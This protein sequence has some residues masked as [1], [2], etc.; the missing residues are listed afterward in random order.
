VFFLAVAG[1]T[2]SQ[3][4]GHAAV[5]HAAFSNALDAG[6]TASLVFSGSALVLG[7]VDLRRKRGQAIRR[8]ELAD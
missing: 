3:H 8:A 5:N 7:L 4:V 2:A 1:F 6:L